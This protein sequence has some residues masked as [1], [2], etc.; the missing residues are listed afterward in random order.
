MSTGPEFEVTWEQARQLAHKSA[1]PTTSVT[2][3]L[4]DAAGHVLAADVLALGDMPPFAASR[5][6][7][8]AVSG[9][10]PWKRVG[11][12]LAGHEYVESNRHTNYIDVTTYREY[13]SHLVDHFEFTTVDETTYWELE[14]GVKA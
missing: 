3:S 4:R 14:Q 1:V 8:W 2:L 6:D 5:I 13:L 9:A 7:G 11:N 10:G 12:A